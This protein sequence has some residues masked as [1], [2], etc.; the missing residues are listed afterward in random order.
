[1]TV[2]EITVTYHY[3]AT[4][5]NSMNFWGTNAIYNMDRMEQTG[6]LDG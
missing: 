1:M 4:L 6:L 2:A 5:R 3:S